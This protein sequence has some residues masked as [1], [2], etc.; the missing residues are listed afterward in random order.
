MKRMAWAVALVGFFSGIA[1]AIVQNKVPPCITSLMDIFSLN[2]ATAGWLSSIFS[3]TAMIIALPAALLLRKFGPKA[4]GLLALASAMIGS[5]VGI[6]SSSVSVLMLSRIIE[7]IGVGLI[8]VIVP[9]LI[10]MWFP[11]E[12]RGLPM[13]IWG[14]WQMVA[15]ATTFF[16]GSNLTLKYGWHGLWWFG[17]IITTIAALLYALIVKS[18]PLEAN[19]ADVEAKNIPMLEAFKTKS[20]W[21]LGG[22]MCFT[23]IACF[24]FATWIAVYWSETFAWDI[25]KANHYVSLI[26]TLEIPFVVAVGW[27]LD[28]VKNRKRI[29]VLATLIYCVLIFISFQ[30][31]SPSSIMVFVII[32]PIFEGALFT[33]YWTL[34]PQTVKKPELAGVAIAIIGTL[35]NLGIAIG[36]P[37]AGAIA[38]AYG[39]G[40][41]AI[42]LAL[43]AVV[44]VILFSMTKIY[45]QKAVD[46]PLT[47]TMDTI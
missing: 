44:T 12:K 24:G 35:S 47:I 11:S 39:W 42:E 45:P 28:R 25:E 31:K 2:M 15:Q 6:L 22:A 5:M 27:L 36:P 38:N 16:L 46:Q 9:S 18:P 43:A 37:L 8:A 19:Y 7:G 33:I 34:A 20:I 41:V 32:Y 23:C 21:L 26:Y 10:S 4:S 17:L 3:V 1:L 13:G 14:S 30:M 40:T 29:G